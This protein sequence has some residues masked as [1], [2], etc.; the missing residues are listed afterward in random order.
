MTAPEPFDKGGPAYWG[1]GTP[2]VSMALERIVGPA[3]TAAY[4]SLLSAIPSHPDHIY[5]STACWHAS[6]GEPPGHARCI[7]ECK[8]CTSPC[9][10]PCHA[11]DSSHE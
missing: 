8:W 2:F 1:T 4:E 11:E 3:E 6:R 7:S 10:C 5:L 9:I